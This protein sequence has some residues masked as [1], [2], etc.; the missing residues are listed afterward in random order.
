MMRGK[1]ARLHKLG[2]NNLWSLEEF[3]TIASLTWNATL[4][5]MLPL[6]WNWK[7]NETDATMNEMLPRLLYFGNHLHDCNAHGTCLMV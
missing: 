6:T 3:M 5:E 4:N 2:K 7:S 1:E